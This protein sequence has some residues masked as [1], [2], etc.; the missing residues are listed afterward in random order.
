MR[1][2]PLG[3]T[4]MTVSELALGTWGLC[5]DGYT[6]V[7]EAEQDRVIDRACALGIT[8]FETADQYAHGAME[9]RLGRMLSDSTRTRIVTKIGS[10]RDSSPPRKRFDVAFLR[11]AFER[12][13]E[14]LRRDTV[15]VVLLHNPSLAAVERGEAIAVMAELV[16]KNSVRSWGVSAANWEIARAA[17]A[18]GARVISLAHN[19]FHSKDLRMLGDDIKRHDAGVLAH[20]VLSYGLLCGHWALDKEFAGGDHRTERWTAD[21]LRRRIRQLDAVRPLV[22]GA[23]LTL[24]AGALRYVLSAPAVSSAVLG[25][26]NTLQLDQ[27][28]REAGKAPPYLSDQQLTALAARLKEA[29]VEL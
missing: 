23:V 10:D 20:S 6:P 25:P 17:L 27:L 24:R 5:G 18:R 9:Q 16:E 29:G 1:K 26:R 28:V 19:A 3:N 11:E 14:R 21:E 4:G 22:G 13:R 2:R 8:L 15:D 7:P 12:S